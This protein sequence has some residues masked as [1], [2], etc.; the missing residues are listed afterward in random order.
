[1]EA[2]DGIAR[3]KAEGLA[4]L[5]RYPAIQVDISESL[6]PIT[7]PLVFSTPHAYAGAYLV[8]DFDE[9]M[10]IVATLRHV[11]L[12]T[13]KQ[14]TEL[15]HESARLVRRVFH[16]SR[17]FVYF[18]ITR[19]DVRQAT[20]KAIEAEARMGELPEEVLNQQ[21]ADALAPPKREQSMAEAQATADMLD[22][23]SARAREARLRRRAGASSARSTEVSASE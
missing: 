18:G 21:K 22:R 5:A 17:D 10:R 20:A 16:L 13:S 23:F 11:A 14:G 8:A 7:V 2:R 4:I 6:A 3:M 9:Y 1:D 12:L 15:R 19:E